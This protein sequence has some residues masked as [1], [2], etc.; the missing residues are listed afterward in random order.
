MIDLPGDKQPAVLRIP[1]LIFSGNGVVW[2]QALLLVTEFVWAAVCM[3]LA[4]AL[5]V[6]VGLLQHRTGVHNQALQGV[7]D[8]SLRVFWCGQPAG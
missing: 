3:V 4:L 7:L 8:A 1:V 2:S 6:V 5:L